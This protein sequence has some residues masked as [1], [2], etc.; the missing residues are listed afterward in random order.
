MGQ[1]QYS[2]NSRQQQKIGV[3]GNQAVRSA[4]PHGTQDG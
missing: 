3:A 1:P 4:S 2:F